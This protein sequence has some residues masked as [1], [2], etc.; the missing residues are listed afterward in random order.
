M[1]LR[2]SLLLSCHS[3]GPLSRQ[4]WDSEKAKLTMTLESNFF[5]FFL[6]QLREYALGEN[7]S[8]NAKANLFEF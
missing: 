5:G 4:T 7:L 1:K 6:A 8:P 3:A 2:R